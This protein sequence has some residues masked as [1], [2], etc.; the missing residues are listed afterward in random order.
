MPNTTTRNRDDHALYR[1]V[2]V[3]VHPAG[4]RAH[5]LLSAVAVNVARIFD[6]VPDGRQIRC[7]LS[8]DTLSTEPAAIRNTIGST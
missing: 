8:I 7:F 3:P 6:H 4:I 2:A 5:L 1:L